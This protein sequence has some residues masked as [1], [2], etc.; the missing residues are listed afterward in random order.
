MNW[1]SG[2]ATESYNEKYSSIDRDSRIYTKFKGYECPL[3]KDYHK[4]VRDSSSGFACAYM[5]YITEKS[6]FKGASK[7][8]SIE[9]LINGD[10]NHDRWV[11]HNLNTYID[12]L[13]EI[14][15]YSVIVCDSCA[16][17]YVDS[18]HAMGWNGFKRIGGVC[19][20]EHTFKSV[21]G[22]LVDVYKNNKVNHRFK[23]YY[24]YEL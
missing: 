15:R 20:F 7:D 21:D 14:P 5:T 8:Y 6:N 18:K 2:T 4:Y 22:Y 1:G 24:S 11:Y 10:A 3:M 12:S 23:G 13:D 16:L 19:P 9:E 17:I